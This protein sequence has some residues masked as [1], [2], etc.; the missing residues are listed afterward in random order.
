MAFIPTNLLP[1]LKNNYLQGNDKAYVDASPALADVYVNNAW[2]TVLLAAEGNGGDTIF[3]LDVTD[4]TVPKF[5]WEFSDSDLFRSRSSPSVAQIGLILYQTTTKW[6]AFFVSGK[7][8]DDMLY[9]SLL[10]THMMQ[11]RMGFWTRMEVAMSS[12]L[13]TI[14]QVWGRDSIQIWKPGRGFLVRCC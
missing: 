7:T 12:G 9:P 8:F 13:T 14:Q 10:P 4:P 3:C 2:R 5:M 1:R 11:V 6:V